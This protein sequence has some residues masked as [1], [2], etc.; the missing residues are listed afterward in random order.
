M[1]ETYSSISSE[2]LLPDLK[3]KKN[4]AHENLLVSCFGGVHWRGGFKS[5]GKLAYSKCFTDLE[6]SF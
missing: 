4:K 2:A 1:L 5:E 6:F 3:K